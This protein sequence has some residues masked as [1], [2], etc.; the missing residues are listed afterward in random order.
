MY[1]IEHSNALNVEVQF[2]KMIGCS[3]LK[4][5]LI[6]NYAYHT[7]QTK[8]YMSMTVDS[9]R[10]RG[11]YC[12]EAI[13]INFVTKLS[14]YSYIQCTQSVSTVIAVVL[15]IQIPNTYANIVNSMLLQDSI[16]LNLFF[17]LRIIF[18]FLHL[19]GRSKR[20]QQFE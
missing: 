6:L 10:N 2:H 5:K 20:N 14:I 12:C 16:K 8:I 3:S 15:L 17:S 19:F 4:R 13:S 18:Y 9:D 1:N 11:F 7:I